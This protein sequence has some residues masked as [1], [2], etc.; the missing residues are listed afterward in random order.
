MLTQIWSVVV[1]FIKFHLDYSWFTTTDLNHEFFECH[2]G[3][4][5][6]FDFTDILMTSINYKG[7][8]L[9]IHDGILG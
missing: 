3:F 4:G 1:K 8:I 7:N 2:G 6:M 9:E 5:R